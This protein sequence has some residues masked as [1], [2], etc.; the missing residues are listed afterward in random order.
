MEPK[1]LGHP[2]YHHVCPLKVEEL[3]KTGAKQLAMPAVE[4]ESQPEGPAHV[5]SESEVPLVLH[6]ATMTKY[7]KDKVKRIV[8]PKPTTGNLAV[9]R[10]I[11][12]MWQTEK[13]KEKLLNMW[14]KSGGVKA[15][16]TGVRQKKYR[17]VPSGLAS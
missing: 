9:P 4:P 17:F 13:G 15:R 1:K 14:C 3:P 7:E 2:G 16:S 12:E 6:V 8:T 5:G 11:Y 10:D